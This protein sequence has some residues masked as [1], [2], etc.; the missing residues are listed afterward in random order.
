MLFNF[1]QNL[2][3]LWMKI[4]G[5][6]SNQWEN[7]TPNFLIRDRMFG[8]WIIKILNVGSKKKTFASKIVFVFWHI[9]KIIKKT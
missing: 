6:A 1:L 7:Q 8:N 5:K 2:K 4:T 9:Y 3:L